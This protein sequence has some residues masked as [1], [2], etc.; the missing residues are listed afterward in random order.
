MIYNKHGSEMGSIT[1]NSFRK[2]LNYN[3]TSSSYDGGHSFVNKFNPDKSKEQNELKSN[4][5]GG[6]QLP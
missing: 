5:T 3:I 6:A 2:S 1:N 4:F